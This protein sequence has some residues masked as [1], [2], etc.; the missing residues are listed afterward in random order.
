M[1]LSA[2]LLEGGS[3]H[4]LSFFDKGLATLFNHASLISKTCPE[5]M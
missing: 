4:E 3:L 1:L 2:L 5:Y